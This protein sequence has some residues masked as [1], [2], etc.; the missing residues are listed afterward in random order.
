ML[1]DEQIQ[2]VHTAS[3]RLLE[4]VGV[5]FMGT[6]ARDAF[7]EAGA[8]VDD[9]TGLVRIPRDVVE[10]AIASAPSQFTV[11]PRNAARQLVVGGDNVS[12]GLVAGPPTVHDRVRGRRS[13]NLDDYVT[14]LELAQSFEVIH[15]IGN[16][17]TSPIELPANTRHLDCYRANVTYTD[18]TFHCLA[19]GRQRTLDGIETMAALLAL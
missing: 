18:R 9:D 16:Q 1:D 7:R 8:I 12:F 11:T 6:A 5:E 19:I 10:Q 17:P 2:L 15:F 13:G 3:L 4:E 14:L